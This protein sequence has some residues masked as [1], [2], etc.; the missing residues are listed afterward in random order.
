M[1][2]ADQVQAF[3]TIGLAWLA[4]VVRGWEMPRWAVTAF[5]EV[6][7]DRTVSASFGAWRGPPRALLRGMGMGGPAPPLA[8]NLGFDPVVVALG[9]H[10]QGRLPDLCR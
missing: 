5:M 10:P 3:E 6:T 4:A 1:L 8:W 2:L 7:A 9:G